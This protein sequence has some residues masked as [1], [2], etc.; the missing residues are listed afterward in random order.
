VTG[1]RSFRSPFNPLCGRA[2]F[3][4][5]F[6]PVL[7]VAY[8]FLEL[9]WTP[10]REIGRLGAIGRE[11][12]KLPWSAFTGSDDFPVTRPEATVLLVPEVQE[13]TAYDGLADKGRDQAPT[14]QRGAVVARTQ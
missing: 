9:V 12:V 3:A 4:K 13:L 6:V 7:P 10:G 14:R 11:V 1:R 2:L 5:L 8:Q